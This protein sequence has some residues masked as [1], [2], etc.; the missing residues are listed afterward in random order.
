MEQSFL[1]GCYLRW[2]WRMGRALHMMVVGREQ[3]GQIHSGWKSMQLVPG[4]VSLPIKKCVS[5]SFPDPGSLATTDW[6]RGM[7][8]WDPFPPPISFFPN[9]FWEWG[10]CLGCRSCGMALLG[11]LTGSVS[12]C[13]GD[14][15]SMKRMKVTGREA[16]TGGRCGKE[17]FPSHF[18]VF[19]WP[20][21]N[22]S[23]LLVSAPVT[24]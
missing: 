8:L 1:V 18:Q 9:R 14:A 7:L 24:F 13:V 11:T 17:H 5:M 10:A 19:P 6:S 16:E 20:K 21:G 23:L 3:Q 12:W 4:T 15:I 2:P 22:I